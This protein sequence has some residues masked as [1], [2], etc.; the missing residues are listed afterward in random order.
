MLIR[1]DSFRRVGD[2]DASYRLGGI[3]DW[4]ARAQHR[5]LRARM[6]DAV[7]LR[8]RIH[9]QNIGITRKDDRGEYLKAVKVALDRRRGKGS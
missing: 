8:R 7:V 5:G 4:I 9:G 2:F 6:L 3:V 1:A